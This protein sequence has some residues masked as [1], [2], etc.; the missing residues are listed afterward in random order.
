MYKGF[1]WRNQQFT[2]QAP[3][4][5]IRPDLQSISFGASAL[6]TFNHDKY[7]FRAVFSHNEW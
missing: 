3:E 2:N 4:I 5:Y 7:S 1:F 6:Y